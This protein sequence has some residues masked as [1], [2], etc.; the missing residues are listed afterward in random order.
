MT[1]LCNGHVAD[2]IVRAATG[3]ETGTLF[4]AGVRIRSR[5]H[6]LAFTTH[7]R[8]EMMLDA[9]AIG[10]IESR[11]TSLL[12]AGIVEVTGNFGVGDAIVCRAP[13]GRAVA[14][15]LVAYTSGD[16]RRIAGRSTSEIQQVL[17]YSNGDEVI[18]RD[19]LVLL[20]DPSGEENADGNA[21]QNADQNAAGNA[22]GDP[23]GR[24]KTSAS[25]ME[26]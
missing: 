23:R 2:S 14:R 16:I 25:G 6:W 11:G 3:E 1:I 20:D 4:R 18:H 10:A 12:P 21:D 5:K 19:D 7:A 13:D 22:A 15:G 17:G 8:G 9:G 24:S 26:S